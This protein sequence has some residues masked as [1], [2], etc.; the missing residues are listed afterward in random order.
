MIFPPLYYFFTYFFH[1]QNFLDNPRSPGKLAPLRRFAANTI[2]INST[3][4]FG[5]DKLPRYL[6]ALT[7]C[8]IKLIRMIKQEWGEIFFDTNIIHI[9]QTIP[10]DKQLRALLHEC[11]HWRWPSRSESAIVDLEE[12]KWNRLK[13]MELRALLEA[14]YPGV[15]D[16]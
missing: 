10:L 3:K 16:A 5:M 11:L 4:E 7:V 1:S 6:D 13:P 15:A 12:I 8:E 14:L 2:Y 9:N